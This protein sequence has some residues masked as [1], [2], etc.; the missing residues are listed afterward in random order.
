MP[1]PEAVLNRPPQ[2]EAMGAGAKTTLGRQPEWL[3]VAG[4]GGKIRSADVKGGDQ[5]A[6]VSRLGDLTVTSMSRAGDIRADTNGGG[7]T[8]PSTF[9]KS[10]GGGCSPNK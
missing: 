3:V 10:C 7:A 2:K 1:R 6:V 4:N 9:C 8:R 5:S